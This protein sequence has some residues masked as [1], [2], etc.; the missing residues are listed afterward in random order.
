MDTPSVSAQTPVLHL[1]LRRAPPPTVAGRACAFMRNITT[2]RN[3]T[4][5]ALAACAAVVGWTTIETATALS[6]R[7]DESTAAPAVTA[8]IVLGAAGGAVSATLAA[9]AM[10]IAQIIPCALPS[11][12]AV[13]Y[14]TGAG[15]VMGSAAGGGA[16][17]AQWLE[18][19]EAIGGTT[20]PW[21]GGVVDD[22]GTFN[23][24]M[25]H[26]ISGST[27]PSMDGFGNVRST[28]HL[29]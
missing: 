9:F 12:I 25:S 1:P 14:A 8:G 17:Y 2:I 20:T 29:D 21:R 7:T 26:P 23:A 4:A 6:L 3:A 10:H 11:P 5:L 19:A 27:N 24:S 16:A 15:M 22:G 28:P 13:A 18:L